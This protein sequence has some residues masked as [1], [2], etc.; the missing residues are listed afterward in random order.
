M[1]VA[2]HWL[3]AIRHVDAWLRL[4]AWLRHGWG[5]IELGSSWRG[6]GTDPPQEQQAV[7]IPNDVVLTAWS[8]EKQVAIKVVVA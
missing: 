4:P 3:L 5:P 2:H 1:M 7:V 6:S 8:R